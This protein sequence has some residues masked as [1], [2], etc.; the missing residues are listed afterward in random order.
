MS[1]HDLP[2]F[3]LCFNNFPILRI[4]RVHANSR[5]DDLMLFVNRHLNVPDQL[6]QLI[7]GIDVRHFDMNRPIPRI[8]P[9]I[10]ELVIKPI[11]ALN[12]ARN[13]FA[14]IP[15]ILVL[16]ILQSTLYRFSDSFHVDS[17][18][19]PVNHSAFTVNQKFCKILFDIGF[20]TEFL[21][22]HVRKFVQGGVLQTIAKAFKGLHRWQTSEPP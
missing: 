19:K 5:Q 11:T 6:I 7:C 1:K 18:L 20:F 10:V 4:Y 21:I 3:I 15:I 2:N 14:M 9:I 8:R 12:E 16:T 17:R 13:T 22:V